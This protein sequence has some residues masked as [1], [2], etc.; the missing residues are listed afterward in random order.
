MQGVREKNVQGQNVPSFEVNKSNCDMKPTI[1]SQMNSWFLD[2]VDS[3]NLDVVYSKTKQHK[4][5][6][7]RSTAMM[8]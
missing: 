7:S 1:L 8:N 4:L 3:A 5:G 6:H 2:A